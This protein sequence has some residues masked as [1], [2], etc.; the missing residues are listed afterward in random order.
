M[1]PTGWSGQNPILQYAGDP[2]QSALRIV[3]GENTAIGIPVTV[4]AIRSYS[5]GFLISGQALSGTGLAID[6]RAYGGEYGAGF[7]TMIASGNSASAAFHGGRDSANWK[8]I[9]AT[10]LPS[11]TVTATGQWSGY[12]PYIVGVVPWQSASDSGTGT[13]WMTLDLR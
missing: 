9:T 4:S 8:L 2:V 1:A 5:G 10:A 13:V 12:Y 11:G 7:W 3:F 6:A